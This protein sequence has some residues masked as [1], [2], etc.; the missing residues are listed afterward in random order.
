MVNFNLVAAI[1]TC[2]ALKYIAQ[3]SQS[4]RPAKREDHG[5]EVTL[6]RI[7][8]PPALNRADIVGPIAAT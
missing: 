3:Y 5:P 4:F 1:S 8:A 6:P 2:L 7:T